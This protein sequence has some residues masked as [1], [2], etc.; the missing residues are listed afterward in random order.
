ML[1]CL[2]PQERGNKVLFLIEMNK[3]LTSNK[4]AHHKLYLKNIKTFK[5]WYG[6]LYY[7]QVI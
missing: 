6:K 7:K 3:V 2:H 5:E 4:S 1:T